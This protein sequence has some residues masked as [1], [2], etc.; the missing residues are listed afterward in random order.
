MTGY[1][2]TADASV[3]VGMLALI[4]GV[5]V[6]WIQYSKVGRTV[7]EVQEQMKPNGGSTLR[8][9]IDRL[10]Y[11]S[12]QIDMRAEEIDRRTSQL[13]QASVDRDVR[14]TDTLDE[15]ATIKAG[16]SMLLD[17]AGIKKEVEE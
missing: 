6:A 9:A 5:G 1:L 8:D 11:R 12:H 16:V 2:T 7:D 14:L 10:E 3:I 17:A 13:E 4:G 15:V